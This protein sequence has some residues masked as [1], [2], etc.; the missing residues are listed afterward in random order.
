MEWPWGLKAQ[1][2][3]QDDHILNEMDQPGRN[4]PLVSSTDF[5]K[6]QPRNP[7]TNTP[8]MPSGL[9]KTKV[10]SQ[11]SSPF[12]KLPGREKEDGSS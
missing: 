8:G 2:R 11:V 1:G 6:N 5:A 12:Y 3:C 10:F 7:A 9:L 4:I